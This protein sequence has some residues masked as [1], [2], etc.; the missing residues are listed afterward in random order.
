MGEMQQ[1]NA[2]NLVYLDRKERLREN[3]SVSTASDV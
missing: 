1:L 2:K 3:Y